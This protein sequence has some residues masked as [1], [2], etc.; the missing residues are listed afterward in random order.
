MPTSAEQLDTR[1]PLKKLADKLPLG[2]NA[3]GEHYIPTGCPAKPVR[4]M[5]AF[6]LLKH[7]ENLS[8]ESVVDCWV[9]DPYNQYFCGM[10]GFQWELPCDPSDRG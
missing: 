10:K 3:F 8:D 1:Q 6:L 2:Q 7:L 9:R 5:V 4:L